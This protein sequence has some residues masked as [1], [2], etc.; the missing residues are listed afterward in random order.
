MLTQ[1]AK[2]SAALSVAPCLSVTA[3]RARPVPTAAMYSSQ[4][5]IGSDDD[6]RDRHEF[7]LRDGP[8]VAPPLRHG[9]GAD[10]P[11]ER[12]EPGRQ[13]ETRGHAAEGEV[14]IAATDGIDHAGAQRGQ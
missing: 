2:P 3:R 10:A 7:L 12:D 8:V 6:L 9:G 13:S 11:G 14:R 5:S 1:R 4:L